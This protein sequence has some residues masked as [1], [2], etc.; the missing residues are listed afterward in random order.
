MCRTA[1]SASG[2]NA[3]QLIL[4]AVS[5]QVDE[6][7]ALFADHRHLFYDW[8]SHPR[9]EIHRSTAFAG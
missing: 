1:D 9:A 4:C 3:S 5:D 6:V 7:N 2:L 8:D